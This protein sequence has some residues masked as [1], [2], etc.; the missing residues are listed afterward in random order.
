MNNRILIPI[1]SYGFDPT[2]VAIPWK[3]LV[4]QGYKPVF[5]TPN[6]EKA[7][8]DHIM[9]TGEGLGIYKKMLKARKD[10]IIAYEEMCNSIDFNNP[11]E[12]ED[13]DA[14]QY[15][16]LYLPGGHDKGVREYLESAVLQ[17][18]IPHFFLT[19]KPVGAIC[20]GVILLAR[21]QMPGSDKP[22][23]YGYKTTALLKK[24]ELLAYKLTRPLL[25]DYYLTYPE[26]TVEDEVL[27]ALKDKDDFI[28]GPFP[29][30][31]D[32]ELNTKHG[33]V[34]I[35]RHYISARWPGDIYRFTSAFVNLLSS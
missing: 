28:R 6:G 16:A 35:D 9:L 22:V 26:T 31:R 11:V 24:Q 12:Y 20:H 23:L 27:G 18:L 17:K 14:S 8:A 19:K 10:A 32:T 29:V 13:I 25:G 3:L 4:R 1:P 15:M 33:F 30:F 5:A 34:C 2:E 7:D 21:S